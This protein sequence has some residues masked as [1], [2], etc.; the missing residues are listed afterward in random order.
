M[1]LAGA[2]AAGCAGALVGAAA[3]SGLVA[4]AGPVDRPRE[5]GSH[6]TPTPTTGGLGII[7]GTSIGLLVFAAMAPVPLAGLGKIAAT[8]GFASILGLVGGL[9][10]LFDIGAKAKLL[11]QLVV[12]L[13]FAVLVARIEAIPFAPGA[14]LPLGPIAGV[15]GT[16]LWLVVVTNAVN[17]MDGANGLAPGCV[18]IVLAALGWAAFLGGSPLLG[19]AALVTAFAGLGFLPWN[20]PKARLFQ[21]DAGALFSSF[22]VAALAVLAAGPSGHGPVFVL[23]APLALLPFLAD[24]LLTLQDRARAKKPLLDAHAEHLY[25]RW[26]ARSGGSHAALTLRTFIIMAAFAGGALLLTG[27]GPRVQTVGF[28]AGLTVAVSGWLMVRRRFN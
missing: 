28:V 9:D 17:F 6:K 3:V 16:G 1:T 27:M 10:D 24:V 15:I 11:I 22:M 23:F 13:A 2:V 7:A 21:G 8:L 25:Q 12:A 5:R 4:W 19:A 20:F 26:L 18:A 14:S